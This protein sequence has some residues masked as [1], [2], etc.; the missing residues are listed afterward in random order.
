LSISKHFNVKIPTY[1]EEIVKNLA[2][3]QLVYPEAAK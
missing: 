1:S 3:K 2:E